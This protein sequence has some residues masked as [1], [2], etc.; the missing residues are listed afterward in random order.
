MAIIF[1]DIQGIILNHFVPPKTTVTG[2]YYVSVIK[3]DP[4]TGYQ[5]KAPTTY[6]V[7]DSAAPR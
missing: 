1:C 6:E 2:N 3:S 5:E 4:A 7:R